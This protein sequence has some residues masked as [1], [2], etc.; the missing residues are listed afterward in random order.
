[1]FF[2]NNLFVVNVLDKKYSRIT[3]ISA[4]GIRVAGDLLRYSDLRFKTSDQLTANGL[5]RSI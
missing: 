2:D 3:A 1:M 4:H 5:S